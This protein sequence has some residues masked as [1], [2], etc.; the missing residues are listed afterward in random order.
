M[1]LAA[2]LLYL[3]AQLAIGVWVSRR[4]SSEADYLIAGRS[5]GPLLLV[6]SVFATWFGAETVVGSAALLEADPSPP[7]VLRQNV[8]SPN[9][10][11]AA[12]LSVLMGDDGLVQLIDRTVDAARRRSEELGRR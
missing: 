12:G 11:T 8:T 10:T 1:I 5:L 7:E 2:V 3:A 4:I 6:F 9:G